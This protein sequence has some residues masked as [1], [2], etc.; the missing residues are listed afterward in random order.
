[1]LFTVHLI[2]GGSEKETAAGVATAFI[3][4]GI[5]AQQDLE[6]QVDR[7]TKMHAMGLRPLAVDLS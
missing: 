3:A 6:I 2:M 5:I 4:A 7:F 1:M